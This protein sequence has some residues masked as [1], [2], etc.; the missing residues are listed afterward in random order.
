MDE[1]QP[2]TT[3]SIIPK[4]S[5]L[6]LIIVLVAFIFVAIIVTIVVVILRRK[7]STAPVPVPVPV[8]V[9][10]PSGPPLTPNGGPPISTNTLSCPTHSQ[11]TGDI[12]GFDMYTN[13]IPTYANVPD[14]RTCENYCDDT[15]A[16]PNC[17]WVNYSPSAKTCYLK[18]ANS[19]NT[20]N[21]GLKV[22][23]NPSGIT[24]PTYS[25]L[26]PG[27]DITGKDITNSQGQ[28]ISTGSGIN[29]EQ[30]CQ[31]LCNNTP[32][33]NFYAYDT[34]NKICYPKRAD[35]DTGAGFSD[36][37]TGFKIN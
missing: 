28:Y 15:S 1:I 22:A 27:Y 26:P 23:G 33:C 29:S 25:K 21:S 10:T 5:H 14:L 4:K 31:N 12:T 34:T 13:K 6:D 24:C 20:V 16:N 35:S 11:F 8:P 30:D 18:K 3:V 37:I 36:I 2:K 19:M 17:H 32:N 7:H 9:P